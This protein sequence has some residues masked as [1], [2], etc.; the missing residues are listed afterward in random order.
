[1]GM[2]SVQISFSEKAITAIQRGDK[3]IVALILKDKSV[4][5]IT[6]SSDGATTEVKVVN[7]ETATDIPVTI[8]E[9]NQR[10]IANALIGYTNAPKEVVV[11]LINDEAANYNEALKELET[12]KFNYLAIPAVETDGQIQT[13]ATWIKEQRDNDRLVKAVL[14]NASVDMDGVINFATEKVYINDTEYTAE[15]YCSRIAGL[16]A[17]TAMSISATYAPLSELTDCTRL[18]KKDMDKAVDA[19]KF[20]VW[21]DGE[22]VKVG[23]AV[24]SFVTTNAEKGDSFKKIKIVDTMDLI[25]DDIK[26]TAQ[27]SYLGKYPNVYNNKCL[28]VAAI[29]AYFD[30]LIASGILSSATVD[31]DVAAN[32]EYL[33][34]RGEDVSNMSDDD[35]KQA[36]TGST[37]FLIAKISILDAIEDIVLPIE[38]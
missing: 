8:S 22:K 6:E 13:V 23:R 29:Q 16:L 38:I 2:P 17:G 4:N 3:G 25:K 34:G 5:K 10:Q 27:D 36:N 37:V 32:R 28:L 14:P 20:I 18:S 15:Q 9:A 35:L 24:N 33:K 26:K 31:I 21:H 7:I 12:I 11:V 1:M 30:L 19:G